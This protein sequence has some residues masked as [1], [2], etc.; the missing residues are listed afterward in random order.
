MS[1]KVYVTQETPHSFLE[2]EQFG[3]VCFVTKDDLNNT[4]GSLHNA[5][6]LRAIKLVLRDFDPEKD[7]I[8]PT[9][10]PYVSAA[11]FLILGLAGH[12]N[13]KVLRWNNRNE[14]Y[15]PLFMDLTRGPT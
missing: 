1:A 4:K 10:S 13:I 7:Y 14:T 5:S 15:I 6:L 9:G 11:V 3:E 12:K 2:A 8:V